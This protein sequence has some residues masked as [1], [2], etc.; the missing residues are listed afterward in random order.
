MI[1]TL[2]PVCSLINIS[3][4]PK[5]NVA[6]STQLWL[7]LNFKNNQLDTIV[8]TRIEKAVQPAGYCANL[9]HHKYRGL[10]MHEEHEEIEIEFMK[11]FGSEE[12]YKEYEIFKIRKNESPISLQIENCETPASF[13]NLCKSQ[14]PN[15]SNFAMKLM[16][17]PAGTSLLESFFSNWTYVH[18]DYRNRLSN[19]KSAKLV[20]IYYSLKFIDMV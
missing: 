14:F 12:C 6:D 8:Q 19:E 13:W 20:D 7:S 10:L 15:L 4:D 16:T 2:D 9:L 3:Q 18:D 1:E 11:E 5:S 17:V